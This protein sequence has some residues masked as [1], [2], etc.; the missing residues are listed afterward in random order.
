MLDLLRRLSIALLVGVCIVLLFVSG[1]QAKA[2]ESSGASE[3]NWS[4]P[5]RGTIT[6]TFGTR[7]G[8]HKGIDIAA[9]EG[10]KIL[11]VQEGI[12]TKSYYSDTYGNVVFIQHPEGYETV[13]AHLHKRSVAESAKVKKGQEI[14]TIGNTGLSRG[15]HLHFE[16]HKGN[17][18]LDK[19]NAVD[20]FLMVAANTIEAMPAMTKPAAQ[21]D[22]SMQI[23]V[24]KGDTLWSISAAHRTSVESLKEL[25]QLKSNEIL[26]GQK[27]YINE[28]LE[29]NTYTVKKGDTLYSIA[30]QFDVSI[31]QLKKENNLKTE[32]IFPLQHLMITKNS[33]SSE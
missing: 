22:G 29:A 16:V 17:W 26:A 4:H 7:S 9:P 27:L 13:Y 15:T 18:T 28:R 19:K 14:G 20:P 10:T 23:T 24:K 32:V 5:I 12:V 21:L 3:I 1:T 11:A 25:N 6:D 31:H 8:K 33:G 2:E 30:D